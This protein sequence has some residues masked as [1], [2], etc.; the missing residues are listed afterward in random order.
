MKTFVHE[1][2]EVVLTG[3]E[4]V[5]K[6]KSPGGGERELRKVEITQS[7]FADVGGGWKKWVDPS[8]LYEILDK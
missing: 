2:T 7:E 1:G 3:R 8:E 6:I 4:A 5:R